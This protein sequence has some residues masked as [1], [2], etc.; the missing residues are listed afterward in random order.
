MAYLTTGLTSFGWSIAQ[1]L[2]YGPGGETAGAGGAWFPTPQFASLGLGNLGGGAAVASHISG[3]GASAAA[4]QAT[5]VGA[6]SV[7]QQWT[8]L[9]SAASPATV[10]EVEDIPV[11]AVAATGAQPVSAPPGNALLRGTPA[12]GAGR[13]TGAG[14][15]HK[16]GFRYSVL[17][18]PPSAG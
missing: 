7:P 16:Y 11:H 3:A 10:T 1:Q 18:R 12:G 4:G 5:Q 8:T 14:Y 13:R 17:I 15:V 9:T 2:T 6:L